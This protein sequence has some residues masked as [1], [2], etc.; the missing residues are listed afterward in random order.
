[1][2]S[3]K[4]FIPLSDEAFKFEGV[5]YSIIYIK[6]NCAG[7]VYA[8]KVDKNRIRPI[9]ADL[10]IPDCEKFKS[11]TRWSPQYSYKETLN[12]LL[13]YWRKKIEKNKN[14]LVR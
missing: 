13:N 7:N 11:H 5:E 14:Y 10:Q 3:R 1:M 8:Y 2:I 6:G 12:D 9:D 4:V